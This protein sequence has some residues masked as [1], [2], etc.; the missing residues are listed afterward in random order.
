M[1]LTCSQW[2]CV[3]CGA[4]PTTTVTTATT[5][6]GPTTTT[7]EAP[8]TT[9]EG[10]D[11]RSIGSANT[12]KP[13]THGHN[14]VKSL[15]SLK[16]KFHWKIPWKILQLTRIIKNLTTSCICCHTALWNINAR[17]QAINGKGQGQGSVAI[18]LMCGR[19]V[20]NQ[21]KKGLLLSLSVN[22]FN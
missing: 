8:T 21:I 2:R 11:T 9:T 18:Y 16:K 1:L 22:F 13:Q 14:S 4:V 10:T 7:T 15:P 12:V 20:N 17:K 6:T 5:T 19:V 3:W